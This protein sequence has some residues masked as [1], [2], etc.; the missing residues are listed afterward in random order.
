MSY[1]RPGGMVQGPMGLV[2]GPIIGV[3]MALLYE[4]GR[5]CWTGSLGFRIWKWRVTLGRDRRDGRFSLVLVY[6]AAY[7][8]EICWIHEGLASC[9]QARR[10]GF[11]VPRR[12]M[13]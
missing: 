9:G 13:R 10:D 5:V 1:L 11:V 7:Y 3:W 2:W 8:W 4:S 6:L 12:Y